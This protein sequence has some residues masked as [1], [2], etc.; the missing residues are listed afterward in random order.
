MEPRLW[1]ELPYLPGEYACVSVGGAR[2]LFKMLEDGTWVSIG[3]GLS[4]TKQYGYAMQAYRK[5]YGPL[6]L[7][8]TDE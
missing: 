1:D 5:F 8:D 7:G 2:N 6:P 4:E 3:T